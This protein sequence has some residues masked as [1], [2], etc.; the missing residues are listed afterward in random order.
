MTLQLS[1]NAEMARRVLAMTI[2]LPIYSD[3][4]LREDTF[5]LV[6]ISDI[7]GD[8]F[9]NVER[10]MRETDVLNMRCHPT[11]EECVEAL[12]W[13]LE[14]TNDPIRCLHI[15]C[16]K[17]TLYFLQD[18]DETVSLFE[19]NRLAFYEDFVGKR[20]ARQ[21]L[22]LAGEAV[23][24]AEQ[25]EVRLDMLHFARDVLQGIKYELH[26][27]ADHRRNLLIGSLE[28]ILDDDHC[29]TPPDLRRVSTKDVSFGISELLR[30]HTIKLPQ[31]L[32]Q[33]LLA[34]ARARGMTGTD[35]EILS[36]L[37]D[38]SLGLYKKVFGTGKKS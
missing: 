30:F 9:A 6:G 37:L 10:E 24:L 31:E 16:G 4:G 19:G 12:K 8:S 38:D 21:R 17:Y 20:S 23:R 1:H 36:K 35:D 2:S 28:M 18:G 5:W 13:V 25:S 26:C 33:R 15:L 29:K 22:E 27:P 34:K 7:L 3:T 32:A 14:K 11:P